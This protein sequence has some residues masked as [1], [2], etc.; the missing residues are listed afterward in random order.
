MTSSGPFTAA[1]VRHERLKWNDL[2]TIGGRERVEQKGVK[3]LPN[4][5]S[6]TCYPV[7]VYADWHS[8]D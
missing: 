5:Q 6:S 7:I 8:G 2:R 4:Q 1:K 3:I